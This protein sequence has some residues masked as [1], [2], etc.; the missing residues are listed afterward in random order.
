MLKWEK[1]Y[2]YPDDLSHAHHNGYSILRAETPEGMFTL[3]GSNYE[4]L[5]GREDDIERFD[6]EDELMDAIK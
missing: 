3:G 2:L 5:P 6:T 4:I 1:H